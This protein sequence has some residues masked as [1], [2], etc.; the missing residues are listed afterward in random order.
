MI[1]GHNLEWD[2]LSIQNAITKHLKAQNWKMD[3]DNLIFGVSEDQKHT[4][5]IIEAFK[6]KYAMVIQLQNEDKKISVEAGVMGKYLPKGE[7]SKPKYSKVFPH[8]KI[9]EA[10]KY[11]ENILED[12]K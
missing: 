4:A 9:N 3:S 6:K 11:F 10:S 2:T 8:T 12:L 1:F 5:I 7:E